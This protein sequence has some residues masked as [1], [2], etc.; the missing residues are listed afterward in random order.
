MQSVKTLIIGGLALF[1]ISLAI[2]FITPQDF[3]LA[4]PQKTAQEVFL[5]CKSDARYQECIGEEFA[6]VM[7]ARGFGF[8]SETLLSYQTLDPGIRGC[9]TMAHETAQALMRKFSVQ[10]KDILR[11]I[12]PGLCGGGFMHGV[13]EARVGDDPRFN[14][15]TRSFEEICHGV[16]QE[17]FSDSCAH[18]LGHIIFVEKE[19]NLKVSLNVC[20]GL[21][22]EMLFQCYGGIFMEDSVRMSFSDH[23]LGPEPFRDWQWF[24]RQQERCREY[25]GDEFLEGGCFFDLAGAAAEVYGFRAANVYDIC[26]TARFSLARERC[27]IR[28]SNIIIIASPPNTN[29][30]DFD[31]LC[32]LIYFD[33]SVNNRCISWTVSA[34]LDASLLFMPRGVRFCERK[35]GLYQTKCFNELIGQIQNRVSR[36]DRHIRFCNALPAHYQE[37]CKE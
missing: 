32:G 16:V 30:N 36:Q 4:S 7:D 34:L 21:T 19:G 9:H 33:I 2:F 13:L 28:A 25:N 12:D 31:E 27:Y 20:R 15:D 17:N 26:M 8:L 11:Q 29:P 35:Q 3:V 14:I 6:K 18:I 5:V 23:G 24:L 1:D 10:W 37:Q 22:G